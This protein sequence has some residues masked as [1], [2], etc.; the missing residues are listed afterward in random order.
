MAK[1]LTDKEIK[2]YLDSIRQPSLAKWFG[3]LIGK[4]IGFGL[5]IAILLGIIAWI[6]FSLRVIF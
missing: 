5:G 2:Q 4:L 3:T 1:K 6:S